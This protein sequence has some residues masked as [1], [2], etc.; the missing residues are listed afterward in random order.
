MTIMIESFVWS[1]VTNNMSPI[2][3]MDNNFSIFAVYWHQNF[4]P[5]IFA[6]GTLAI[7]YTKNQAL[8]QN[9]KEVADEFH[10]NCCWVPPHQVHQ[11]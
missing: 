9:L 1:Y 6:W 11:G 4:G 3:I 10:F 8:R 5:M 2:E 7:A